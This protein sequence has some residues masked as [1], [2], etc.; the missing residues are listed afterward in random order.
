MATVTWRGDARGVAEVKTITVGGTW[1]TSDT[2]TI[3]MNGKSITITLGATVT[4]A[5]VCSALSAAFNGTA[6]VGDE[7]RNDT[8]N[9]VPEMNEITSSATSTT[10]V[11]TH[12]TKG[13]PFTTTVAKS[14]AAGTISI[15]DTTDAKGTQL[16][17]AEN[18]SGGAL[19]SGTDDLHFEDSSV[20]ALYDLD[21]ATAALT[22]TRIKAS[23]TGRIGLPRFNTNSYAEYRTR[24]LTLDTDTLYIGEGEGDGSGRLLI[25]LGSAQ[26]AVYV[27]KTDT[28]IDDGYYALRIRGTNASN[29][30][31]VQGQSTVDIASEAGQTATFATLIAGGSSKVRTWAGVTLT[32]VIAEGSATVEITSATALTDITTITIRDSARVILYGDNAIGTVEI[33]G[34]GTFDDRGSGT[35]ATVQ[36]GATGNYTTEFSTVAASARTLTNTSLE[37]GTGKFADPGKKCVFTNAIDL[38]FAGLKNFPGLNLGDEIDIQRS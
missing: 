38:G 30:M 31:Q 26:A 3:T 12:D 17:S 23:Y 4:V 19:P 33:F 37:A 21:A 9:N 10:V 14:S 29:T 13:V 35:I 16:L 34:S 1:A 20:N 32:T 6:L 25:N 28:S 5:H 36:K 2:A 24:E 18:L 27:Y 7:S 22:N 8:G 11:L 15:A